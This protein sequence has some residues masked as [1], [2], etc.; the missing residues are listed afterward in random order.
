M[1]RPPVDFFTQPKEPRGIRTLCALPFL[2]SADPFR[3]HTPLTFSRLSS[4]QG[5][6]PASPQLPAQFLPRPPPDLP[7]YRSELSYHRRASP[8]NTRLH[9]S[10]RRTRS[11]AS[12]A[13]QTP[14]APITLFLKIPV[15]SLNNSPT[16]RTPYGSSF[17]A[18][19]RRELRGPP[20]QGGEVDSAVFITC[21][22]IIYIENSPTLESIKRQ[23]RFRSRLGGI[24]A[25][26]RRSLLFL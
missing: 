8:T 1:T 23:S 13:R 2:I 24:S 4:K 6:R 22:K 21:S 10:S 25:G 26:R 12:A 19:L 11:S 5:L 14:L 20:A 17:E 3:P 7:I 16:R 9:C 15:T 18:H